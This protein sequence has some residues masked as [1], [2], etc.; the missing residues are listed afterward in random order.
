MT[1]QPVLDCIE[2]LNQQHSSLLELSEEKRKAIIAND[3]DRLNQIVQQENKL[4]NEIAKT[5]RAREEACQ[6]YLVSRGLPVTI[7]ITVSQLEKFV[8]N[9]A[10]KE[11]LQNMSE[12]LKVNSQLLQ[13]RN[14]RNQQ[15]LSHSLDYVNFSLDLM[16]GA[17]EDEVTYQNP[18]NSRKDQHRRGV[19]DARA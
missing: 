13:E 17:P 7:G 16:V 4:L 8:F 18:N 1:L 11:A 9:R 14:H 6:E 19:F 10:E 2:Q 3:I 15:L 12:Q 5:N